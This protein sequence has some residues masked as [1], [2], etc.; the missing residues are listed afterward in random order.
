MTSLTAIFGNSAAKEDG[1]SAESEKLLDLYWN[2]AEL[3]KEFAL[4]R[5]E[6]FRLEE[7]VREEQG[8]T[9]GL[10]QKL[11]HLENLL[12]DPEWVHNVIVHYQLRALDRRCQRKLARFAEELKQKREQKQ[13]RQLLKDWKDQLALEL[14]AIRR[15]IGNCRQRT[16]Q[17]EDRLQAERQRLASMNYFL[18]LLRG[19]ALMM[20]IDGLAA[21]IENEQ[22]A[23]RSLSAR[24]DELDGSNPPDTQ[25]L[26]V[27]TK[28]MI[29]FMILAYGQH[30]YQ[31]F[32]GDDVA[33]LAKSAAHK[34][35][36]AV[37]YG[38]KQECDEILARVTRRINSLENAA[39]FAD[40]LRQR[41]RLIGERALFANDDEAVPAATTVSTLY[42]I[43]AHGKV[44]ELPGIDLIGQNFW[45]IGDVVSR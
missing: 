8:V 10:E 27:A 24:Y 20:Q 45:K 39:D 25:G 29:N 30:L 18:R 22:S 38:G 21:D 35:V 3:K 40:E 4:L 42:S 17:L 19:R 14:T 23:E 36:G 44:S 28:R 13:H 34:S 43:D 16:K 7:R 6:K 12:S 41:A 15:E 11:A 9:A 2:R 5:N 33:G 1:T 26:N 37:N 32:L 31:H